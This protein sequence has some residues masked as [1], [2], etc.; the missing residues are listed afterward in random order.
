MSEDVKLNRAIYDKVFLT[1]APAYEPFQ[2][3]IARLVT[4]RGYS[5]VV[6]FGCGNG[7]TGKYLNEHNQRPALLHGVDISPVAAQAARAYYDEVFL[8]DDYR[9]PPGQY[10]FVVMNSVIEHIDD[11]HL[12]VLLGDIRSKLAPGGSIFIVVPNI[13][14]PKL[15]F[16]GD[17]EKER[18]EQGHV[19][20]KTRSGWIRYLRQ[21][22]FTRLRFS[23]FMVLRNRR[24]II[25]YPSSRVLNWLARTL[26]NV[27]LVA[28]FY[29]LRDSYYILAS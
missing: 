13:H 26:Y 9:L 7:S 19:N 23:H 12:D 11:A 1:S 15:F 18:I 17:R 24:A 25:Y 6:D 8:K 14:S 29:R 28:P 4:E 27:F 22:G 16:C 20:L 21:R 5:R 3:I 2:E 10:D